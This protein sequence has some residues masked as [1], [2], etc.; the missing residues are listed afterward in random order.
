MPSAP[1][2]QMYHLRKYVQFIS[3]QEPADMDLDHEDHPFAMAN[4]NQPY[5][6]DI[7]LTK[8]ADNS[9]KPSYNQQVSNQELAGFKKGIKREVISYPITE[10]N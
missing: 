2:K 10:K 1:L 4:W 8:Q 9:P 3:S 6:Y 5:F 7:C